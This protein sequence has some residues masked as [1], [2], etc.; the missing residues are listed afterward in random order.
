M[1]RKPID[2][3]ENIKLFNAIIK[4]I[5]SGKGHTITTNRINLLLVQNLRFL[6]KRPEVNVSCKGIKSELVK[7][8]YQRLQASNKSKSKSKSKSTPTPTP[9]TPTT[10][11][12]SVPESE[13][14][15]GDLGSDFDTSSDDEKSL[16]EINIK[17]IRNQLET[18]YEM[19]YLK[20][21]KLNQLQ[22]IL[23]KFEDNNIE[24]CDP[25]EKNV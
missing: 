5:K 2:P 25:P 9:T 24:K 6:C 15:V 3:K 11:T 19:K 22:Q 18:K 23:K 7:R 20:G 13:A 1:P 17:H 12:V 16:T 10:P 8:I 4:E 14:N 21:L